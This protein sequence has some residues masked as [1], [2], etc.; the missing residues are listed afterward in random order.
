MGGFCNTVLIF[1]TGLCYGTRVASKESSINDFG[2]LIAY[3]IPGFAVLW[4]FSY[5][6]PAIRTWIGQSPADTPTIAGFLYMTIAAIACGLTVSTVR[7]LLVDSLHHRTGIRPPDWDFMHLKEGVAAFGLLIEIHY[8]YYQF[9]ANMLVALVWVYVAR[10]LSFG[11][12]TAGMDASDLGFLL[13]AVVLFLGSR[14]TLQK[15]Y[16]RGG[17]LLANRGDAA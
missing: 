10:R 14:D 11:F 2:L 5:F 9:Y 1:L 7:W 15:Y 16:R 8:R 12:W 13:L 3:V 4:G 17:Q 6:S